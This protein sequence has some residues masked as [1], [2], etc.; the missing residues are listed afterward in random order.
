MLVKT[1]ITC[2]NCRTKKH[3]GISD[4]NNNCYERAALISHVETQS[5]CCTEPDY[6]MYPDGDQIKPEDT[7]KDKQCTGFGKNLIDRGYT[8]LVC[9]S[10]ITL[11]VGNLTWNSDAPKTNHI[12]VG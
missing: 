6:Y 10:T 7:C 5:K 1:I 11:N 9:P 4:G 12:C 8:F 2:K 3:I